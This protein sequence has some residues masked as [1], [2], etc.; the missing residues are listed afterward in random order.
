MQRLYYHW[1][2]D[3]R[4][5]IEK[6]I[7][8]KGRHSQKKVLFSGRAPLKHPKP[9]TKKILFSLKAK[10]AKNRGTRTFV[11]R[12][13]KTCVCLPLVFLINT[14]GQVLHFRKDNLTRLTFLCNSIIETD[15]IY[16]YIYLSMSKLY[17]LLFII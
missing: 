16:T 7:L 8:S 6:D 13:K 12:S 3:L 4:E 2:P 15:C 10:R 9:I 11:V 14:L 1:K 17:R 5:D